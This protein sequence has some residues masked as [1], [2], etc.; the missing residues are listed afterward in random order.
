MC[1]FYFILKIFRQQ[2]KEVKKFNLTGSVLTGEVETLCDWSHGCR[3]I[4]VLTSFVVNSFIFTL[5]LTSLQDLYTS[6][7][8]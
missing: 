3:H 7:D 6:P 5:L 8:V 4:V 2:Y 1:K